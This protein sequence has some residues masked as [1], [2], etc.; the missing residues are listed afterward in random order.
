LAGLVRVCATVTQRPSSSCCSC[1][2]R[3]TGPGI[4]AVAR[5]WSPFTETV[6]PRIGS[7]LARA[8]AATSTRADVMAIAARDRYMETP[9]IG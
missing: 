6:K 9:G 7:G 5:I 1:A 2:L 8:G 3:P 4:W